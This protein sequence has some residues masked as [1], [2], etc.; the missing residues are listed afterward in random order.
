MPMGLGP[1]TTEPQL[2]ARDLRTLPELLSALSRIQSEESALSSSLSALLEAQE[3]MKTSLLRLSSLTPLIDNL[4]IEAFNVSEKVGT[5]AKTAERVRGKVRALDEEMRRV[6]EASERVGLVM[7]LKV[8]F[9]S[10]HL[11]C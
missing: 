10:P 11:T 1:M 5:T 2:S 3:P 4:H 9:S 6:R 7:D 8:S